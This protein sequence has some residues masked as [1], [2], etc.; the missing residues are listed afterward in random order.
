MGKSGTRK[1]ERRVDEFAAVIE[2]IMRQHEGPGH[3]VREEVDPESGDIL[4][5]CDR[6]QQ[7]LSMR[8]AGL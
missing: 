4:V 2:H 7:I 8:S 1:R 5:V 6:C 3:E